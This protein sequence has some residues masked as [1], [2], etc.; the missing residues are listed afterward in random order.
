MH[1]NDEINI[2][3]TGY[4]PCRSNNTRIQ[5]L[6]R[7]FVEPKAKKQIEP[8]L[9]DTCADLSKKRCKQ[10]TIDLEV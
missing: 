7:R 6:K 10:E 8:C 5:L 1:L 9:L 4:V 3:L 2:I